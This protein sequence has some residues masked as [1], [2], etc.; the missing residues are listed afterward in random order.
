[1]AGSSS[2]WMKSPGKGGVKGRVFVSVAAIKAK[3]GA[4]A[5]AKQIKQFLALNPEYYADAI[6]EM[7]QNSTPPAGQA[8]TKPTP[9][10]GTSPGLDAP[11]VS[12][13]KSPTNGQV[14][15]DIPLSSGDKRAYA[16][17]PDVDVGEPP[18]PG[19]AGKK[20]SAGI[21]MI[22]PDGRVWVVAPSGQY[23]GYKNTF[24]KGTLEP[25]L[26]AQQNA[27][28]EA[29]EE[30]GLNAK[31]TGFLGD[32]EGDTSVTR[33]Y[34]GQRTGGSPADAHWESESV[35]LATP[36]ELKG[37]LNKTRDQKIL[38]ALTAQLKG[39]GAPPPSAPKPPT[40]APVAQ[41]AGG[42]PSNPL[43]LPKVG[44]LGGS[45]GAQLVQGPDGAK[46][47]RKRGKNAGHLLEEGIADAA[48]NALGIPVPAFSI[49]QTA[50]GPVK[51]S[52][53]L[54]GAQS[55]GSFL[56]GS[57]A[58]ASAVRKQLRS[59]FAADALLANWDVMGAGLDNVLVKDGVAYR[60]D[61]GGA[62]RYRAQGALK[63][64][65][66]GDIPLELWSLRDG[67]NGQASQA[68]GKLTIFDIAGQIKGIVAKA[69]AL[70]AALA[71]DVRTTVSSRLANMQFVADVAT[72]LQAQG[73]NSSKVDSYLKKLL[74]DAS[75]GKP[76]PSVASALSA[77]VEK[78]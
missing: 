48:Y 33:Y 45:T 9:L 11:L 15:N 38:A 21:L 28:K 44:S 17:T 7:A 60:V 75:K 26:S 36:D 27:L 70:K 34:I 51:L 54:E 67:T 61:N 74:T 16:S 18:F 2:G 10:V 8:K 40:P 25:G 12:F 71:P 30:A 14:I 1:M 69:D 3:Y 56:S 59:G 55:I 78:W 63:G 52:Q 31:I 73:A 76:L 49:T 64:A 53:F 39:E 66:F 57:S 4:D 29:F 32:F 77:Y 46:Y 72:G 41:A 43:D 47:I 24:P 22:E 37:L 20:R 6:A 58:A 65:S 35:R 19:K 50:S 62:L 42:F 68:F 23:G 13:D 5:D